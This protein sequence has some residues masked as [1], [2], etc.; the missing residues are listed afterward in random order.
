[1]RRRSLFKFPR[2]SCRGATAFVSP[3]QPTAQS[4]LCSLGA[5]LCSSLKLYFVSA[6]S[7]TFVSLQKYSPFSLLLT[8]TTTARD[9]SIIVV[10]I[11]AVI[12]LHEYYYIIY[13]PH[14]C[15]C[16]QQHLQQP[17]S[18]E[19]PRIC[20]AVCNNLSTSFFF[21]FFWNPHLLMFKNRRSDGAGY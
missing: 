4:Q 6:R 18:R 11:I 2:Y 16:V 5:F 7:K 20:S 3:A 9:H 13:T 10:T 21:S 8:M 12:L 15:K 1:M 14:R 17:L 19:L